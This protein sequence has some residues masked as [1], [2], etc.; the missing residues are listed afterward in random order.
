MNFFTDNSPKIHKIN[1]RHKRNRQHHTFK[2]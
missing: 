1:E 2:L